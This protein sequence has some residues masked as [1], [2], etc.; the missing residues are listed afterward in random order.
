MTD[1]RRGCSWRCTAC[2][3]RPCWPLP[4]GGE[5]QGS[6][7]RWRQ[8]RPRGTDENCS[9]R[10]LTATALI[11]L[12]IPLTLFVGRLL[13]G[14]QKVLLYRPVGPAGVHGALFP[15]SLRAGSPRARELV[16][17]AVLC[18]I[19]VAGRAALFMLPQFKPVL[20]MTILAGVAFGGETG[21][22]V[23]AM[24]MLA[25]QHPLIPGAVDARGRCLP[26]ASSAFWRAS[27]S[28]RACCA[29]AGASL[30]AVWRP[31]RH[32]DLRR[33][34]EPGVGAHVGA[35]AGLENSSDVLYLTDFP[36][37]LCPCRSHRR[38]FCG[39]PPSPC[40][41]SWTGSRSNM[42]WWSSGQQE[43]NCHK[44]QGGPLR[45]ALPCA[46]L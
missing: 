3:W 32:P 1:R 16:I 42:G 44:G 15:W 18:A 40:W 9:R 12:L 7:R 31:V 33:H 43:K 4:S 8:S 11:L 24:T 10:T 17:I 39:L 45:S 21:F 28:E 41:R 23:G 2:F 29:A 26:W 30:C 13:S 46:F 19:G 36:M 37:D 20:A 34:Y 5:P 27:C 25:V 6:G 38:C 22:L 14:Q 35:V